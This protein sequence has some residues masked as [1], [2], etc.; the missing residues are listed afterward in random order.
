MTPGTLNGMSNRS[1][2]LGGLNQRYRI[3]KAE[4]LLN[5]G[6]DLVGEHGSRATLAHM[7]NLTL[8]VDDEL[9][10]RA[11]IRAVTEHTSVNSQ[12][13]DFLVAYAAGAHDSR[14]VATAHLV[15]LAR[16]TQ[17]GGG[18]DDR[19]WTRDDLHAR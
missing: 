6:P 2:R 16:G 19:T 9:L 4:G 14:R 7:T 3:T 17:S 13:R 1:F 8:V 11:R 18:M 5:D 10:H 15:K 12:V